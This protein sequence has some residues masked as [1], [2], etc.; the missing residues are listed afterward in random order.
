MGF[1]DKERGR[2]VGLESG[3]SMVNTEDPTVGQMVGLSK[4]LFQADPQRIFPQVRNGIGN[5]K[6]NQ[7]LT[8]IF[9]FNNS[10]GE[11]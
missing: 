2:S 6:D 9:F 3:E 10:F 11:T 4:R 1:P 8:V 7:G 5:F